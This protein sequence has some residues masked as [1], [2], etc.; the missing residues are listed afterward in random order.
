MYP[1]LKYPHYEIFSRYPNLQ[2]SFRN[3]SKLGYQ[4]SEQTYTDIQCTYKITKYEFIKYIYKQPEKLL[5]YILEDMKLTSLWFF[6]K[7][8]NKYEVIKSTAIYNSNYDMKH[9]N[10]KGYSIELSEE[11]IYEEY[12]GLL[13]NLQEIKNITK[14]F[15]NNYYNIFFDPITS[16]KIYS[17][18][19]KCISNND[20][21]YAKN[22]TK[23]EVY[24]IIDIL[25]QDIK[26]LPLLNL[27]IASLGFIFGESNK[28]SEYF[29]IKSLEELDFI[30]QLE[31]Y[32]LKTEKERD[33]IMNIIDSNLEKL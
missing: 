32:K 6:K 10:K 33:Y 16:Y 1:D 5:I 14:L 12:K 26:L 24:N 17:T 19:T 22:K 29:N 8:H 25:Q 21:Y 4:L 15:T 27:Y 13:K 11:L 3:V 2:P 30:S 28:L 18:R 7:E 31:D 20:D 23:E 9:P